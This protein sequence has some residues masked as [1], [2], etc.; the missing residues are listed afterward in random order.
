MRRIF[1][2]LRYN[3]Q[4]DIENDCLTIE[5][6][7]GEITNSFGSEQLILSPVEDASPIMD[8]LQF[9]ECYCKTLEEQLRYGPEEWNDKDFLN[10]KE[11][12]E[13]NME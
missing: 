8:R 7:K 4:E 6:I 11:E 9:L 10:L 2:E 3:V 1:L 12:T 5:D 13:L